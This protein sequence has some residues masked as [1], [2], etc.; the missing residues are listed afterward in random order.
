MA[1]LSTAIM[2]TPLEKVL[3]ERVSME[4]T[5]A[6]CIV[7]QLEEVLAV[8]MQVEDAAD[9]FEGVLEIVM[10]TEKFPEQVTPIGCLPVA[11]FQVSPSKLTSFAPSTVENL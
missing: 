9:N 3:T 10:K 4:R 8:V 1:L 7:D 6:A 2:K 5:Q 11:I